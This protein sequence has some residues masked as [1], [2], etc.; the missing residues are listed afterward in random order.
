MAEFKTRAPLKWNGGK[1]KV[2]NLG[3]KM[4]QC[5]GGKKNYSYI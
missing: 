1:Q 4:T 5:T 3:Q 2:Q